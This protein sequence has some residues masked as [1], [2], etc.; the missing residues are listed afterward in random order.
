M[1]SIKDVAQKAGVSTA[2]VS[3]VI[4]DTRFVAEE[5]KRKVYDAMKEL[6]YRPNSVARSLRSRKSKTIGLLVPILLDDTSNFFFMSIAQGIQSYL[7]DHGYNLIFSNSNENLKD[8]IEQIKVLNSQFIDGLIIAPTNH[9][10]DYLQDGLGQDYPV[11]YIDRQPN[12]QQ[13]DSILVNNQ[14]GAYMACK[15]LI[16]KGHK[17]IGYISGELGYTTSDERLNGYKEALIETGI[18]INK[19][20]IKVGISNFQNGYELTKELVENEEI[21]AIFIANNVLSMG[22]MGYLQEMK[23]KVPNQIAIIGYDDYDW[24]KITNPPLTVIKQPAYEI[25]KKAAEVLLR[26][27]ETDNTDSYTEYRL[28]PE[29]IIRKSC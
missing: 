23:V 26:R 25:G 22:A 20:F 14:Q 6:D 12:I 28:E 15:Y 2:T 1:A 16:K 10:Y 18:D 5:T 27:I 21:T 24:T 19:H 9:K 3:H 7:K 13:G 29:L 11:V 17:K 4:N 8:E